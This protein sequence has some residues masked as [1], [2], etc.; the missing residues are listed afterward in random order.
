MSRT[1]DELYLAGAG[2]FRFRLAERREGDA[3]RPAQISAQYRSLS[4]SNATLL[5]NAM[6]ARCSLLHSIAEIFLVGLTGFGGSLAGEARP[7]VRSL[8]PRD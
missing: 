5:E 3:V 6:R 2:M 1:G 7:F 8:Q 4:P